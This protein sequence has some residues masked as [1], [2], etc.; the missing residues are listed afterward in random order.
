MRIA[1]LGTGGVGGYFGGRLAQAGHHVTFIAR[2]GHLEAIR[3]DGLRVESIAGDFHVAPAS[4]TAAPS[5]IGVVDLVLVGVKAPRVPEAARTMQPMVGTDT[6]VLPLQNGVEAADQLHGCRGRP[7]ARGDRFD[8]ARYH[9]GPPQR[10][11]GPER[12][13]R[14]LGRGGRSRRAGERF[15]PSG[16]NRSGEVGPRR[17]RPHHRTRRL[18]EGGIHNRRVYRDMTSN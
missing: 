3:R 7:A 13:R 15:S 10:T 6:V 4:A 17:K 16:P 12:C 2:G 18:R 9:G 5:A 8:A 11:A 1:V 14:P